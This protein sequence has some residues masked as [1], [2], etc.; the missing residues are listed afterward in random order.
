MAGASIATSNAQW[1][2]GFFVTVAS[3]T[4]SWLGVVV[5]ISSA[6]SNIGIYQVSCLC[7]YT[8]K[9]SA[10]LSVCAGSLQASLATTSRALW[11]MA[12]GVPEEVTDPMVSR[13]TPPRLLR[14]YV[15]PGA[16]S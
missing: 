1:D 2:D 14:I 13:P 12:G 4:A 10:Q 11:A 3:D 16:W 15:M 7:H 6:V 8:S 5:V 9:Q